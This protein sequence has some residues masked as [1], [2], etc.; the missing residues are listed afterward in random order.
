MKHDARSHA[1]HAPLA[2]GKLPNELLADLIQPLRNPR[3]ELLTG[4][5]VGEDCAILDLN[6]GW[7]VATTDPITG[8][9]KEIGRLGIHVSLNDLASAGAEPVAVLVTLLCPPGTLEETVRAIMDSIRE[10]AGAMHIALAG[11]HTEVTDAVTRT[12]L[13]VTALGRANPGAA[14]TTAGARP[15]DALVMTK[16]AALEG[17]A[18]LAREREAELIRAFGPELVAQAMACL[19]DISVV[20]EGRVAAR[21]GVHAMHDITEGGVLGAAWELCAASGVRAE[22]WADRIPVR[23]ATR[24]ICAHFGI[25]PFRLISSGSMLMA[26]ADGEA[27]VRRLA[28][29]GIQATVIGTVIK[30]EDGVPNLAAGSVI[31]TEDG[32]PSLA[33]D[34][35]VPPQASV[36]WHVLLHRQGSVEAV[37][38]PGAD[39]LYK[40]L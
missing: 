22:I 21:H 37:D 7:L 16:T 4:P 29:A 26:C 38:A 25:D 27:M 39:E 12:V 40:V 17:T 3:P 36:G 28:D 10:T 34:G 24:S 8:S 33:I 6:G 18:I 32:V 11:G 9:D 20:A 2:I 30:T 23:D 19:D 5:A 31:N 35:A 13:S 15:G 1:H 14:V